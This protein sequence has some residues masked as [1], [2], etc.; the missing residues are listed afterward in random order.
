MATS[1]AAVVVHCA[2]PESHPFLIRPGKTWLM[3]KKSVPVTFPA[4]SAAGVRFFALA[5]SQGHV[6]GY[7]QAHLLQLSALWSSWYPTRCDI[8]VVDNTVPVGGVCKDKM[9]SWILPMED[10]PM[11]KTATTCWKQLEDAELSDSL[12]VSE[13]TWKHQNINRTYRLLLRL[14]FLATVSGRGTGFSEH[15]P[16]IKVL[17]VFA[18]IMTTASGLTEKQFGCAGASLSWTDG[19]LMSAESPHLHSSHYPAYSAVMQPKLPYGLLPQ[20]SP[21]AH[22]LC[23]LWREVVIQC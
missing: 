14:L 12:L 17:C 5:S 20:K 16:T 10:L 15:I 21:K 2:R 9:A 6:E 22:G 7:Q 23:T 11:W 1:V 19:F 3:L 4:A 13:L 8:L 18:I